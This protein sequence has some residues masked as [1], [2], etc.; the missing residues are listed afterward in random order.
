MYLGQGPLDSKVRALI[1]VRGKWVENFMDWL[2]QTIDDDLI[3]LKNVYRV[4]VDNY[5]LEEV[6]VLADTGAGVRLGDNARR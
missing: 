5:E 4:E 6:E 2:H 3:L 1:H